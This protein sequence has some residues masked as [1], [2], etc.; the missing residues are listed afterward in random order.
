MW[1]PHPIN[2]RPQNIAEGPTPVYS[3][4]GRTVFT[5]LCDLIIQASSVCP[6]IVRNLPAPLDTDEICILKVGAQEAAP[7]EVSVPKMEVGIGCHRDLP[8]RNLST[9][10]GLVPF[11]PTGELRST[12][13]FAASK[14]GFVELNAVFA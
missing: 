2:S 1:R 13:E 11:T 5:A 3:F 6:F 9:G 7:A 12:F 10:K 8:K 4:V 14:I